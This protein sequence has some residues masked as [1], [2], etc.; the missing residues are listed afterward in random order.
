MGL[1]KIRST[2]RYVLHRCQTNM[3]LDLLLELIDLK[4]FFRKLGSY[5]EWSDAR[6]Y[7]QSKIVSPFIR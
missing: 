1:N 5:R 4:H 7:Q 6:E 2:A 3:I